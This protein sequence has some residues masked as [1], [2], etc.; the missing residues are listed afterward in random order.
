MY[1]LY[2]YNIYSFYIYTC[3]YITFTLFMARG[4]DCGVYIHLCLVALVRQCAAMTI[5]LSQS[6]DSIT[7]FYSTYINIIRFYLVN[8]KIYLFSQI[9][10]SNLFHFLFYSYLYFIFMF[11]YSYPNVRSIGEDMKCLIELE[12]ELPYSIYIYYLYLI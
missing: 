8:D 1:S 6:Y 11:F 5:D 2:I 4:N 12:H 3:V 7:D 10:I 9:G